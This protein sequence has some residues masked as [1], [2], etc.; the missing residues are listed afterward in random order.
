MKSSEPGIGSWIFGVL[1]VMIASG[2]TVWEDISH[3]EVKDSV[4]LICQL[5][6]VVGSRMADG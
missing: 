4:V 1:A 6:W 5:C 2:L 3:E